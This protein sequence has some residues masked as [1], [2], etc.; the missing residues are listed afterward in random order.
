[1][2]SIAFLVCFLVCF[3]GGFLV[4]VVRFYRDA[5]AWKKRYH[6]QKRRDHLI[7]KITVALFLRFCQAGLSVAGIAFVFMEKL[8]RKWLDIVMLCTL[9]LFVGASVS[10][11]HK[12]VP[13][14]SLT[15]HL[16]CPESLCN[17]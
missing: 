13:L 12:K 4:S 6:L 14:L 10:L 1:M 11:P 8:D 5:L 2:H 17:Q 16:A 15:I 3:V 9:Q 7:W